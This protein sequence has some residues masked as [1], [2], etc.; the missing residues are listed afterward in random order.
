MVTT[1]L[2]FLGSGKDIDGRVEE[3]VGTCIKHV[4][5]SFKLKFSSPNKNFEFVSQKNF[6]LSSYI[7]SQSV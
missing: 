1:D 5:K 2:D 4:D 3:L 7:L 6:A